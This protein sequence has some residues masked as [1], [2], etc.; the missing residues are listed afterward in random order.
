MTT[1]G[2]ALHVEADLGE[3]HV[4]NHVTDARHRGQ[5]PGEIADRL[6]G[7]SHVAIHLLERRLQ[8]IDQSQMQFEEGT[9]MRRDTTAQ[10]LD[11]RCFL[12]AGGPHR[13]LGEPLGMVF[14]GDDR[15]EHGASALTQHV[16]QHTSKLQVAS[17]RIFWIRDEC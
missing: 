11:Q 5:Q 7:F 6:Q 9:V 8:G 16:G 4:S 12:L 15:L 3:D 14:A 2:E 10:R 13:E 17:S 1:G